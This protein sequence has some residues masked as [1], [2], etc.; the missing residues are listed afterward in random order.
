MKWNYPAEHL[1]NLILPLPRRRLAESRFSAQNPTLSFIIGLLISVANLSP[2]LSC[3]W[4][5]SF[6]ATGA[7]SS[8]TTISCRKPDPNFLLAV[9]WHF[10]SISHR[11]LAD[12]EFYTAGCMRHVTS[13]VRRFYRPEVPHQSKECPYFWT[14]FNTCV[15]SISNFLKVINDFQVCLIWHSE[16]RPQG[17]SKIKYNLNL[18]NLAFADQKWV[19]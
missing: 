6:T 14:V 19:F 17:E 13:S 9:A 18:K 8:E 11:L 16:I 7:L 4:W 10:P 15:S 3:S 1:A 5:S 12:R 2:F